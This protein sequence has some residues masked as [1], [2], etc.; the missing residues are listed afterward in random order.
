MKEEKKRI[1][2]LVEVGKLSAEEAITLIEQLEKDE[3]QTE[4]KITALSTEVLSSHDQK[5][6]EYKSN[7]TKQSSLGSK[8]MEW[9]DTAVKKVKE[10]DLDLNFGKAIDVH[11]IFQYQHS[12]FDEIDIALVNGSVNVKP[13]AEQDIRVECDAKVYRVENQ[14]QAREIFLNSVDCQIEGNKFRFQTEK[15]SMKVSL[16]LYIPNQVYEQVKVKLFNGPIRGEQLR[17]KDLRAKTA[18]GVVSFSSV[19]G[20]HAEL[21]TANG[22][23]KAFQCDYKKLEAE[24]INGMI[25]IQGNS[26]K[27]DA[28]SFNGNL[29]ITVTDNQCHTL[30]AKTTTGNIDIYTPEN[31]LVIGELKTNLGVLSAD[32]T[33][34][35]IIQEKNETIQKELRFRSTGS[36]D[37]ELSL[38]ADSK[39]GSILIKH[40]KR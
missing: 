17:I 9:V 5:Q 12:T 7:S 27:I 19:K 29:V 36:F 30:Y 13:W 8:L 37:K 15:K 1:L 14:D 34:L 39:T 21:E 20:E 38:F 16:I 25:S 10:V 6:E 24:S 18:N 2:K 3:A 23:I 28:Q 31:A 40:T 32:L 22:Q 11:H 33:N 26:E 4:T 35:E